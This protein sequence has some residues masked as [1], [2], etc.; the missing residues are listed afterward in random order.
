MSTDE[1]MRNGYLLG[2]YASMESRRQL[3][4]TLRH[5]P[6]NVSHAKPTYEVN[7]LS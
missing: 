4:K 5:N 1:A 3:L 2:L 7:S 6:L